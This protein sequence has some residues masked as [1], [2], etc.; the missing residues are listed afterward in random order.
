MVNSIEQTAAGDL[1]WTPSKDRVANAGLTEFIQWLNQNYGL[2]IENYQQL[3]QWSV[4]DVGRFW[5]AIGKCYNVSSLPPQTDKSQYQS[6]LAN[7]SMP[8]SQWFQGTR[9][10]ING[11]DLSC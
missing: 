7:P 5:Q 3:W 4:N 8:G 6:P 9:L 1:L 11:T 2:E 10:N